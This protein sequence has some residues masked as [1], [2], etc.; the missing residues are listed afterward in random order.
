M[1]PATL[2]PEKEKLVSL[3]EQ[4][5]TEI[6]SNDNAYISELRK[7]AL[8]FFLTNGFPTRD[9]EEWKNTS[10]IDSLSNTYNFHF[11]PS[12]EKVDIDKI[13][14]C[15]IHNFET[16]LFTQ[17]NGWYVYKQKPLTE[18]PN[19]VIAGS[20]AAAF[21][22]YPQLIEK[23]Y[24][25]AAMMEKNGLTS[26]NTAFA[27]DGI[28]IFIPDGVSIE[29]PL[30]IVNIVNTDEDLFMQPRNLIILGKNSKLTLVYCDDSTKYK[31]SFINACSEIFLDNN[32][33]LDY[34]KLQNKDSLST[35]ITTT[36]CLL[37]ESAR[38]HTNTLTLNGGVVRNETHAM[39]AGRGSEAKVYGLYLVDK[40]QHV[41]NQV[42][43]DHIAPET[44]SYEK[45]KGI[46]DD[47]ASAV[48]N[49]H[50]H[51]CRDAQKTEAYQSNKNILLTDT[52]H[53]RTKPF[54]EIYADDVKCSHGATVGQLDPE[55]L[56]YL[57]SRGICERN[58]RMLLMYAF[59][60]E[61]AGKI[62]I[63]LL[64]ERIEDMISKRLKGELSICDQCVLHCKE[65][66]IINF[67]IDMSKV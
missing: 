1:N 10:L 4:Y 35:V 32:S 21:G 40:E 59:A 67:E 31:K 14:R 47:N 8:A 37:E 7:K 55:A 54:L 24:G 60:I 25:R 22:A 66:D 17:L 29:K 18:F 20:L 48:F 28:F 2:V 9:I 11:E 45:F 23:Y 51:V 38:L 33:E 46:I 43:V 50:I 26:L 39:L 15:E 64:R 34:Y 27:Q 49:G 6:C 44:T 57:K 5:K 41:D 30:Q 19:G 12:D 62:K 65:N 36:F 63:E 53:V 42:Y 56:F 61:I 58:A 16:L 3:F 13:F 52:A